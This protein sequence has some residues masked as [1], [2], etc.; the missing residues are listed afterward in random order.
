[1]VNVR[2]DGEVADAGGVVGEGY[3]G[4]AFARGGGGGGLVEG[5]GCGGKGVACCERGNVL[6]GGAWVGG[7]KEEDGE[8]ESVYGWYSTAI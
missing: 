8:E 2:N 6:K 7:G 1:M 3:F 4:F 5:C